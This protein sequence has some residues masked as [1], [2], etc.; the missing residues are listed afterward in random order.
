MRYLWSTLCRRAIIDK[1]TDLLSLIDI[2][3][4]I[5]INQ[6]V[7]HELPADTKIGV[8]I[9][10]TFVAVFW[11][12]EHDEPVAEVR[13][14]WRTPDGERQLLGQAELNQSGKP[15]NSSH[16]VLVEIANA[17]YRGLGVYVL[18]LESRSK[19]AKKWRQLSAYPLVIAL[20]PEYATTS[21]EQPS[22]PIPASL[23][24]SS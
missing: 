18:E 8:V 11:Y 4:S 15:R 13:L 17:A 21:L 14:F 20:N 5:T 10:H 16:R 23:P 12:G 2:P 1:E 22:G 9:G 7:P 24:E 3:E 6:V 19:G